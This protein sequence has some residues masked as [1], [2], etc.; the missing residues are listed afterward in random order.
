MTSES[1]RKG[2]KKM[3]YIL[4]KK[5]EKTVA[6]T[7]FIDIAEMIAKG[8]TEECVIRWSAG[9]NDIAEGKKFNET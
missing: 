6:H 8:F 5:E 9:N 7:D 3:Y 4:T 2:D 1:K